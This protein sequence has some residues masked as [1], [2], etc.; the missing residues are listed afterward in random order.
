MSPRI[1]PNWSDVAWLASCD[2]AYTWPW[3]ARL[4]R[5]ETTRERFDASM[6]F[7]SSFVERLT[8]KNTLTPSDKMSFAFAI[9]ASSSSTDFCLSDHSFALAAQSIFKSVR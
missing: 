2:R 5:I 9:A 4:R 7:P 1:L 3:L 8:C 6:S